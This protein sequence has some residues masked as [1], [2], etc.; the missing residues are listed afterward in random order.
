[1]SDSAKVVSWTTLEANL[2]PLRTAGKRIVQ[3]H[4][5]FDV[6][7]PGHI[8]HFQAARA[9]GDVLV[10]S[11]TPD[12]FVNKGPG[13][14]VFTDRLRLQTLAAL[15]A[16]NFVV[17]NDTPTAVEAIHRIRPSVYV[18][19]KDYSDRG[20][21]LTGKI[22]DE[23]HAVKTG[24]GEIRFTE[25]ELFSS[26]SLA[27]RFFSMYS[28]PTQ[29][30]LTRFRKAHS[31]DSILDSLSGLSSVKP[32]V[33]GEAILD[34]YTYCIPL[35]KS[36]KEFIVASRFQSEE[37]FAGGAL[38]TANHLAGF[39]KEVILITALGEDPAQQDFVR[40]RLRPNIRLEAAITEDRPTI[41][42]RRFLEPNF[43]TKMFEI[44]YLEDTPFPAAAAG[45][46]EKILDRALPGAD[47]LVVNDFGHGLLTE[48]VKRR[49]AAAGKFMAVNTQ[50][51]SANL[52]FNTITR[53]DRADYACID[54]PELRLA[55]RDKFRDLREVGR[56]MKDELKARVLMVTWGKSGALM[57]GKDGSVVHSPA[58]A[59]N[60]V[61]RIGAGDAFFAVTSPCVYKEMDPEIV[62][63]IGNCVGALKVAIVCNRE[64]VDPVSLSKFIQHL[65]K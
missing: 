64:P 18:K 13:R 47:L 58:L 49:L 34:Q 56:R 60:V 12:R 1:V 31:A 22:H 17:L 23:E 59:V 28:G 41:V 30:Y 38:A 36:P 44:Q 40:S 62:S 39:C 26:S 21:D 14:P 63:F 48:P 27:N 55:A 16:V 6:L 52:G 37:T 45:D 33:I 25:T 3:C 11:V 29:E 20:A 53:Y 51:N 46:V 32:I 42:K 57:F 61:D 8:L 43:L 35:A 4:G 54:E 50:T 7:H 24:G 5:V 9:F 65:L 10:V 15:E 19:G 2:A